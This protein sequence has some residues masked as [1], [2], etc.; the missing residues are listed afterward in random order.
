MAG[1]YRNPDR[2]RTSRSHC[3]FQMFTSLASE[4]SQ[5]IEQRRMIL[6]ELWI[7]FKCLVDEFWCSHIETEV[8][9]SVLLLAAISLS[10]IPVSQSAT[11]L[12]SAPAV[13]K[14]WWCFSWRAVRPRP[15]PV[16]TLLLWA[17]VSIPPVWCSRCWVVVE[18]VQNNNLPISW[19]VG[20]F[21]C[22]EIPGTGLLIETF[23]ARSLV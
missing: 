8:S 15:Y 20:C 22:S 21:T 1:L 13:G 10:L 2:Q 18:E 11:P 23:Q 17:L 6:L 12:G 3:E 4:T 19:S 5:I 14:H 16:L 9:L 7:L